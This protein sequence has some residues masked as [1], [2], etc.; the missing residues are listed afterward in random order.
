MRIKTLYEMFSIFAFLGNMKVFVSGG[1]EYDSVGGTNSNLTIS[2]A[3]DKTTIHLRA[4]NI[5]RLS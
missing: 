1:E 2:S 4:G 3:G 5:E